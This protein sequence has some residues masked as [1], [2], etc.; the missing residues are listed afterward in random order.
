MST[1]LMEAYERMLAKFGRNTG[2]RAIRRSKS[3]SAPV[4]CRTRLANVEHA[5]NNLRDAGVMGHTRSTRFRRDLAEL[6]RPAGYYQLKPSVC[7]ILR[8]VVEHDGSLE[9]MFA[10][11]G[12]AS[13]TTTRDQQHRSRDRRCNSANHAG[14]LPTFVVDTTPTAF[15]PATAGSTTTLRTR[16]QRLF[17]IH[18]AR[19]RGSTM[20][21]TRSGPRRQ[22]LKH[23]PRGMSAGGNAAR[24]WHRDAVLNPSRPTVSVGLVYG[25]GG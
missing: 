20:N 12:L 4:W 2:G 10:Q 16:Y 15:W 22:G 24:E 23:G 7:V 11:F 13:R 8:F 1:K 19:G 5:I 21:I 3:W 6:I 18:F 17:R 9:S 14:G 25:P